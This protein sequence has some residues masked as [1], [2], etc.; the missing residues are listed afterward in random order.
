[1]AGVS[2]ELHADELHAVIGTNG[3]GKSTLINM[4]SGEM[5]AS[6]GRIELAG[7]DITAWSQPRRARAGIGRSYPAHD[8]LPVA[9]GVRERAPVRTGRAATPVASLGA[10]RALCGQRRRR[11]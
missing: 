5:P 6:S 10:G 7:S 8:D 3:A 9:D 4:L 1:M 11:A 2:L